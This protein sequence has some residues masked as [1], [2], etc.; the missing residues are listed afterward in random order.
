MSIFQ[1]HRFDA[2]CGQECNKKSGWKPATF[3]LTAVDTK[4]NTAL[5]NIVG[6]IVKRFIRIELNSEN[7]VNS[8]FLET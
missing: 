2:T 6:I 1:T 3:R 5:L 7:L 8:F 4:L